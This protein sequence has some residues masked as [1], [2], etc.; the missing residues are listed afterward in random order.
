LGWLVLV[1]LAALVITP[2]YHWLALRIIVTP[3]NIIYWLVGYVIILAI[4]VNT[5]RVIG[6]NTPHITPHGYHISH[7][8]GIGCR[9][10]VATLILVITP[11]ARYGRHCRAIAATLPVLANH[12]YFNM[13]ISYTPFEGWLVINDTLMLRL[14]VSHHFNIIYTH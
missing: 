11:L 2:H 12:C 5:F 9:S 14:L 7:I 10:L 3:F 13:V 4:T 8:I 6:I 1:R